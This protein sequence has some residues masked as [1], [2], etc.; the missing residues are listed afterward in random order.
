MDRLQ[1]VGFAAVSLVFGLATDTCQ[2]SEVWFTQVTM[3]S[4]Y[5]G[6]ETGLDP[7]QELCIAQSALLSGVLPMSVDDAV[8]T[9]S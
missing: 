7:N 9:L 5:V 1:C 3:C 2:K 4:L 6:R 8:L